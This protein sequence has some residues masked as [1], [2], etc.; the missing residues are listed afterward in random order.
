MIIKKP[1]INTIPTE[2][3]NQIHNNNTIEQWYHNTTYKTDKLVQEQQQE[4]GTIKFCLC[5]FALY[6][7]FK[8]Y[9]LIGY[10]PFN[11]TERNM[12]FQKGFVF[13]LIGMY[14]AYMIVI[15][16]FVMFIGTKIWYRLV[17]LLYFVFECTVNF[18]CTQAFCT[19]CTMNNY[20]YTYT[21]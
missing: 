8:D 14:Q 7:L 15:T 12:V 17:C 13:P 18:L 16:L 11:R 10:S 9:E 6:I 21:L 19:L 2:F 20:R 1:P 3:H 5:L 4:S